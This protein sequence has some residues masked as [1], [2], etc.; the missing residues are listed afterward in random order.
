MTA[1]A[2]V[3]C[4]GEGVPDA[5]AAGVLVGAVVGACDDP[6]GPVI[7][8]TMLAVHV[9][10]DPPTF[11]LPL[12]WLTLIGIAALTL[13]LWSTVQC[14]APPPPLPEPL[15]WVT[16]LPLTG[17]G[18]QPT[19]AEPPVP[20]PTHWVTVGAR[21]GCAPVVSRQM[22]LVMVTL[23]RIVCAASL[24][25]LLHCRTSVTRLVELV[26]VVPFGAEQGPRV[27]SR[28]TVVVELVA[29]PLIVLTTVTVHFNAVVAPAAEGP[30]LLHWST[31]TV[32][33]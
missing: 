16:M 14:T 30:W 25:E 5:L 3:A 31:D 12:H 15:H 13:E 1:A 17:P 21:R 7:L 9:S 33:A 18:W 22:L 4:A 6:A 24:S 27:H 28:V 29:V 20:E 8:V 10:A 32:A 19:T 2:M 23:Q 11:P 26:V